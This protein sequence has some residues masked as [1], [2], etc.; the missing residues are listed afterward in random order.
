MT[1]RSHRL[2]P[3]FLALC[4]PFAHAQSE[5]PPDGTFSFVLENDLFYDADR[6]YTN[7]VRFAW[8][9]DQSKPVPEWAWRTAALMPWYPEVGNIRYGYAFGQSLFTPRDITVANPAEGERPYAAWLYGSIGLGIETGSVVDQFGLTVGVV[10]PAA[11]GEQ[12]QKFVHKNIGS[13]RPEGWDTQLKNELGVIASWQRSWRDVGRTRLLGH[14]LDFGTHAGLTLGNV[15]TYA[16]SGFMVR[17]GP[18]LPD[19][20][21]PPRIQPGVP[22]S[23]DFAPARDFR[24]YVFAGVEGR[25]V[26]R[27]LFLDG[28]TF[29]DSR[30]VDK[31][32]LVGDVQFGVVLDWDDVRVSYTHVIRSREFHGQDKS[33]VFGALTVLLRI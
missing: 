32:H 4:A 11:L 29:R 22:G 30:S 17:F 16:S 9:P 25:A 33:D 14:D 8:V 19:D 12:T 26:A 1:V 28:N 31:R 3:L 10:G 5:P 24:W 2:L 27:N 23:S 6:H 18:S 21:G 20:Y 13:D 7:G 15:L